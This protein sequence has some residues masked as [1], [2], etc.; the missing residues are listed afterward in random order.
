M[1]AVHLVFCA[2]DGDFDGQLSLEEF[3]GPVCEAVGKCRVFA[4]GGVNYVSSA[5]GVLCTTVFTRLQA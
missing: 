2:C 1:G 4:E 3:V 5:D